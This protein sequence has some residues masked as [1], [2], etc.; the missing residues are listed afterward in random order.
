MPRTVLLP[1]ILC[2]ACDVEPDKG[3]FGDG[4][5]PPATTGQ[6]GTGDDADESET[7]PSDRDEPG[8]SDSTGSPPANPATTADPPMGTGDDGG[9]A[10]FGDGDD[11]GSTSGDVPPPNDP[12]PPPPPPPGNAG[13]CCVPAVTAGCSDIAIEGCVCGLDS[14]CCDSQWDDLCVSTAETS[15]GAPCGGA[16][17]TGGACCFPQAAPGCGNAAVEACVCG[18]DPFC[19]S[20][21]WDD[22]CASSVPGCGFSC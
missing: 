10:T 21:Q 1:L 7:G 9:Q 12:P 11:G 3:L 5:P 22:L 20:S 17:G 18:L 15:C 13:D 8:E 6:A 4:P 16:G 19:C 2:V 14:F